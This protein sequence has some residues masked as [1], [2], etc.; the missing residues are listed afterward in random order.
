MAILCFEFITQNSYYIICFTIAINSTKVKLM[1][2]FPRA[3]NNPSINLEAGNLINLYFNGR[4]N[5]HNPIHWSADN[6]HEIL[7]MLCESS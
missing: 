4:A 5:R 2:L 1:Y 6:L 7:Q 3:L